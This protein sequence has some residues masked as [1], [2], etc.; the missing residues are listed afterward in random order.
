VE[1]GHLINFMTLLQGA[2]A[3]YVNIEIHV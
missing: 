2:A 1:E 3:A